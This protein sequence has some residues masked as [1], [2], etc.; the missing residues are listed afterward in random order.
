MRGIESGKCST[1]D[2]CLRAALGVGQVELA[3]GAITKMWRGEPGLYTVQITDYK[4]LKDN[5]YKC[6]AP[7]LA[8]RASIFPVLC[9]DGKQTHRS[10]GAQD[11]CV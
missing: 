1:F 3:D 7:L 8:T 4:H 10:F 2:A 9:H 11:V 5:Q 6:D